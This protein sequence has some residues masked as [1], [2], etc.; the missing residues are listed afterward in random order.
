MRNEVPRRE[1][2]P[3][4]HRGWQPDRELGPDVSR[5]D[6]FIQRLIESGPP[7]PIRA[8]QLEPVR[9]QWLPATGAATVRTPWVRSRREELGFMFPDIPNLVR[10]TAKSGLGWG[11]R[12][13]F[14]SLLLGSTLD[15]ASS[16]EFDVFRD[17]EVDPENAWFIEQPLELRY[18]FE[19]TWRTCR[20]DILVI[21]PSHVGCVEVKYEEQA[22]RPEAEAK[23]EAIGIA[24]EALGMGYRVVTERDVRRQPRFKNVAD[25]LARRHVRVEET[26]EAAALAWLRSRE[27]TSLAEFERATSLSFNEIL[28]MAR[29]RTVD[30]DLDTALLGPNTAVRLHPAP[31]SKVPGLPGRR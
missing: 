31:E 29:R 12:K 22:C 13:R 25:V 4:D 30:L 18:D 9:R 2:V 19:G 1:L 8:P 20:P 21:R 24:F 15:A 23:W 28:S 10:R 16:L 27:Q 3:G 6:D 26:R 7:P 5:L 17:L 11:R 14:N